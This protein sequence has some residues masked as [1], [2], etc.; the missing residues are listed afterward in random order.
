MEFEICKLL[1]VTPKELGDKRR[2]DPQ[3]VEFLQRAIIDRWDRE[4]KAHE[5]A[6]RKAKRGK[7]SIRRV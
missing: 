4:M 2:K 5:E 3:G 1:R 7:K 6:E